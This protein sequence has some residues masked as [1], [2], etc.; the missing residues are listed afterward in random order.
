[1]EARLLIEGE[2][3]AL[4]AVHI[5][6]DEIRE[7]ERLVDEM[8]NENRLPGGTTNADR[9]FHMLIAA[10]TPTT[11]LMKIFRAGTPEA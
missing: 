10:A 9:D 5:H 1:M 6:D 3:A 11:T 8:D 4:A 2:A 7:L